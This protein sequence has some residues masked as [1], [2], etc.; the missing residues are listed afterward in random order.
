M[1]SSLGSQLLLAIHVTVIISH[2]ADYSWQKYWS[3]RSH[4]TRNPN[5]SLRPN[6]WGSL[7]ARMTLFSM[8]LNN[9]LSNK[10]NMWYWNV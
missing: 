4:K 7:A 6:S 3:S 10:P 5:K 9:L 8:C 1:K 2:L